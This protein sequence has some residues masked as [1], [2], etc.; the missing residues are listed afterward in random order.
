MLGFCLARAM[1]A[2]GKIRRQ[3]SPPGKYLFVVVC[4]V[5]HLSSTGDYRWFDLPLYGVS[6][7]IHVYMAIGKLISFL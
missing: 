2:D 3:Q 6:Y 5:D 1:M 4:Q 7:A